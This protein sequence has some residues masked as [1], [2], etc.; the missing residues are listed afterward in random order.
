MSEKNKRISPEVI[1]IIKN[2][3]SD[4][5]WFKRSLNDFIKSVTSDVKILSRLDFSC[6]KREIVSLY[7]DMLVNNQRIYLDDILYIIEHLS[8]WND[9]YE[10]EREDKKNQIINV[11][12]NIEL[13]K[14]KSRSFFEYKISEERRKEAQENYRLQ[15]QSKK[16]FI[17]ELDKIKNEYINT[18]SSSDFQRKGYLLEKILFDINKLFDLDPRASYRLNG[19][20]IDGAFCFENQEFLLETKFHRTPVDH[21]SIIVFISK[22]RSKLEN[23]LGILLSIEDFTKNAIQK[24]NNENIILMNGE[25][26]YYVLDNRID[27]RD[28]LRRKKRYAHQT[29]NSF[30]SVREML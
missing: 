1:R 18:V 2:I 10:L 20:Q 15:I 12:R 7:I 16:F 27:F 6:T 25:D 8:G 14:A 24:A 21:N 13:L 26:L 9:F 19:E 30:L 28:L 11:K 29:G 22:V 3:L 5:F 17:E 4:I 23:T